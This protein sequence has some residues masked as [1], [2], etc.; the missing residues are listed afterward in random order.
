[1]KVKEIDD[2]AESR[3]QIVCYKV[4]R[5]GLIAKIVTFLSMPSENGGQGLDDSLK[6]DCPPRIRFDYTPRHDK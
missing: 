1:M 2:L 4:N 6:F 5:F 3:R